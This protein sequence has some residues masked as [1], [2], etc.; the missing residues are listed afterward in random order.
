MSNAILKINGQTVTVDV[1]SDMPLLGVQHSVEL[2]N[3][4]K[5]KG[6]HDDLAGSMPELTANLG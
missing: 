6:E 2:Y 1:P 4:T 3:I 5:D